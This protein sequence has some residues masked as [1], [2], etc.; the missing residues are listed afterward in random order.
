[1]RPYTNQFESIVSRFSVYEDQIS[2]QVTI[3]AILELAFHGVIDISLG[4]DL[5]LHKQFEDRQQSLLNMASMSASLQL[6]VVTSKLPCT[7]NRSHRCP[8]LLKTKRCSSA[9]LV[10]LLTRPERSKRRILG[11]SS[12]DSGGSQRTRLLSSSERIAR[13][14]VRRSTPILFAIVV[15]RTK[16]SSSAR[17]QCV[18][19]LSKTTNSVCEMPSRL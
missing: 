2:T 5:V 4:Q 17:H 14:T 9:M 18:I 11:P 1:M 12:R 19:R 10:N 7:R 16:G 6:L 15:G 8:S 13:S 3:A